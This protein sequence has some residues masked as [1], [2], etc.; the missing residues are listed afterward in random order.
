MPAE[1]MAPSSVC[2]HKKIIRK[3]IYEKVP[4]NLPLNFILSDLF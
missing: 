3:L 4:A 2:E 1:L